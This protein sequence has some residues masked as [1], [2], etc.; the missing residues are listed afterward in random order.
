MQT[1]FGPSLNLKMSHSGPY[2]TV[3]FDVVDYREMAAPFRNAMVS[4]AYALKS[5]EPVR[6]LNMVV[7]QG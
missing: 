4:I 5:I 6:P 1:D 3:V 7:A 2:R